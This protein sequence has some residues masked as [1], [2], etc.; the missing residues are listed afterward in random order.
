MDTVEI[1]LSAIRISP[2]NTRQ[3]LHSGTEDATLDDLADSIRELGLL[4]PVT[5]MNRPDGGY[6]LI[7]GQRRF[8]ACKKV[9]ITAIPAIVRDDLDATDATVV[10]LVENVHRA[11]MSPIDKARAYQAIYDKYGDYERVA[12][13]TGMSVPTIR[14]YILL[15]DLAPSIQEKVSTSEGPAGVG[16]LSRLAKEFEPEDQEFVLSRIG[17]F[18]SKI[19]DRVLRE[20]HGD[21]DTIELLA[22]QAREGAFDVRTCSEGLCFKMSESLKDQ[23]R[24]LLTG[25]IKDQVQQLLG[26]GTTDASS[27]EVP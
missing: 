12:R 22:S 20:S 25:G 9:G 16:T 27:S 19:Q 2:Q 23:V 3:D 6:D 4:Q 14:R 17:G 7:A 18:N 26:S 13:E 21:R 10:S 24:G 5:V 1:P 8:L 15:L 11:D